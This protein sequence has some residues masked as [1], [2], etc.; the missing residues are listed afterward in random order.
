MDLN[1]SNW[2]TLDLPHDYSIE[3]LP[4]QQKSQSEKEGVKQIGPFSEMS[5]G[6]ASTGHTVGGTA[7]YRKHFTLNKEDEGKI[8]QVLFDGV[9]I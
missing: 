1:D 9:Y 3:D 6:G 8:I 4:D 2:R 5:A 7:W